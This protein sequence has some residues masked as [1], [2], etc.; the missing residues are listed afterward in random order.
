MNHIKINPKNIENSQKRGAK[1]DAKA[2]APEKEKN[3]FFQRTI[4]QVGFS[5]AIALVFYGSFKLLLPIPHF[6]I[7]MA[8][9][10]FSLSLALLLFNGRLT[11]SIIMTITALLTFVVPEIGVVG[12][13]KIILYAFNGFFLDVF[14]NLLL[15][16]F[17]KT[18][19]L[20]RAFSF[21]SSNTG[22][23]F[24]VFVSLSLTLPLLL[25]TAAFVLSP[26]LAST[27]PFAL[28]NL[29]LLTLVI[30]MISAALAILL[31]KLIHST[32]FVIRLHSMVVKLPGN[33][34]KGSRRKAHE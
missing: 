16:S 28:R 34:N 2:A 23:Y 32:R 24:S 4:L 20:K 26:K 10:S 27:F 8:M 6:I 33:N 11:G 3:S 30:S 14:W 18:L 21:L 22:A 31:W 5:L 12:F 29:L 1:V 19:T 13:R 25:L 7:S 9:L 17:S 15:I